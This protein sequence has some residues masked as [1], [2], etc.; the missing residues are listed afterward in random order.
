MMAWSG[1]TLP[2]PLCAQIHFVKAVSFFFFL[3]PPPSSEEKNRA[4]CLKLA[5]SALYLILLTLRARRSSDS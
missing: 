3:P 4:H 1:R 2:L 5:V